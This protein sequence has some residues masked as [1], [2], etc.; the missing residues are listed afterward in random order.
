MVYDLF[1]FH[2]CTAPEE[3]E[4]TV[5]KDMQF[6]FQNSNF[7]PRCDF[8]QKFSFRAQWQYCWTHLHAK[9]LKSTPQ[10]GFSYSECCMQNRHSTQVKYRQYCYPVIHEINWYWKNI[11]KAGFWVQISSFYSYHTHQLL[12]YIYKLK[13]SKQWLTFRAYL[14]PAKQKM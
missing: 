13:Q 3:N 6:W 9:W 8:Y 14:G 7:V 2:I 10:M 1:H 11:F 4:F 5:S 12:S